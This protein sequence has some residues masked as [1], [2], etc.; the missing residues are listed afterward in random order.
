MLSSFTATGPDKAAYLMLKHLHRSCMDFLH[1]FN[2]SRSPNSF[3]SIW[4]TLSI[5]PIYKMGKTILLPSALSLSPAY[6]SFLNASLYF[7]Y[8]SF[9]NLIPFFF[10]A[11]PV[12]ALD[13]LFPIKFCYCLSPFRMGLTNPGRTLKRFS[14][15]L[16]SRK[17]STRFSTPP[18]PTNSLRL[19]SLLAWF[20]GHNLSF[21][22]GALVRF[23]KIT[24]VVLFESVKVFRK[25]PFLALYL[26][27]SSSLISL[28]LCLL[29]SAALFMLTIWSSSPS[30]PIAVETTQG[31][32]IRLERWSEYWCLPVNV[33]KCEASFFSVD[34]H[35]ANPQPNFFYS[36][37]ASISIPLQLFLGSLSTTLFLKHVSSL[38]AKFL[39]GPK[40][41]PCVSASFW[42]PLSPV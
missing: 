20:V 27:L 37:P 42:A 19:A 30:V 12:S 32:L 6:Q 8:S 24:K 31:A 21:L 35:Q 14:L 11:R 7:V 28:L 17:L 2:L 16:I 3:P 13:G 40:V 39:F 23:I 1:I 33:N 10:P 22:I 9:W 4:K 18:F 41:I 29:P 34:S 25:A 26:F 36:T 38:K 15:L 5:I